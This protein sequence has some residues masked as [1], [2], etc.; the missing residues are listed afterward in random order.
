MTRAVS[1]VLDVAVSLLLVSAAVGVVVTA[2]EPRRGTPSPAATGETLA[3]ATADVEYALT[4]A[5]ARSPSR[6]SFGRTDGPEFR[7]AAHGTLADLLADA[8]LGN[9][10]VRDR[11]VTRTGDGFERV[12][13]A[14]TRN[15]TGRRAAVRAV[16]TPYRGAPV[17][18][19]MRAGRRPPRDAAV[20]A[21]TLSV[22]SDCP[23]ARDRALDAANDTGYRGVARAVAASVV[24]CLFPPGR[25]RLAL[26]GDYPVSALVRHRYAR[27]ARLAGTS[28][29]PLDPGNVTRANRSLVAAL[30]SL[31]RDD[32]RERFAS[33]SAAARAVHVDEV[34]VVVR[35]WR[36]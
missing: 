23:A 30:A 22:A 2:P 15:A 4:P 13:R 14:A 34:R 20:G 19:R 31:F 7:R 1:T 17:V 11:E 3:T 26:A 29:P 27:V 6:V 8:A 12:V 36:R 24:A 33:P 9:V 16:W 28:L 18:G 10:S 25:T 35:R 5:P 21:I 32:M